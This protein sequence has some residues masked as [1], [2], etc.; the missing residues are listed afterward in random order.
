MTGIGTIARIQWRINWQ[1]VAIW[2]IALA[3]T[4]MTTVLSINNL[5]N[6]QSKIDS[7]AAAV[8]SGNALEA[9]NGHVYGIDTLGGVIANEFGF[10]ASIALPLMAI[11]L[12]TR[13]TRREEES[14]RLEVLLSGRI[15]RKAPVVAALSIAFTALIVA[16]AAMSAALGAV[17][18]SSPG[19]IMYPV[20]LAALGLVFAGIS[21]V[22]AQVVER[23]REV[24]ATSLGLL[25][26][27]YVFR[28]VGDV[29][30]TF[31]MWLSPLGWAEESRPFGA[32]PRWWP[33]V[34]SVAV[35]LLLMITAA[36]MAGGRDA[37]LGMVRQKTVY[38]RSSRILRTAFGFSLAMHRS[39]IVRWSIMAVIIGGAFG[40]ITE[41]A[42][43]AVAGNEEIG[44]IF[45]GRSNDAMLAMLVLLVVIVY[46]AYVV[47]HVGVFQAE[48]TSGRLES[49]LAGTVGRFA[50]L[51]AQVV[52]LIVGAGVVACLGGV[53]LGLTAFWSTRDSGRIGELFGATVSY[54]PAVA[55]IAGL[56]LAL[57]GLRPRWFSL[58]WLVYALTVGVMLLGDLLQ[59]PD[60]VQALTPMYHVGYPPQDPADAVSLTVLTVVAVALTASGFIGFGRRNI[61]SG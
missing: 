40:S 48:E 3:A 37:G 27:A 47:Q 29:T 36:W 7:Y 18:V 22:V 6:T 5:Y 58:A 26:A 9:I 50:W 32:D 31:V 39:Q 54:L 45:R 4:I 17:Q 34:L 55:V 43:K 15:C 35:A 33:I 12:V 16:C 42:A 46:A 60:W 24:Y 57:F 52:V 28:G 11:V 61:P 59:L 49:T 13:M 19:A 23:A 38:T 8:A 20:S 51:A 2:V 25:V 21:A 41:Q 44:A 53:A 1:V 30:D 14:G 56:A 10:V